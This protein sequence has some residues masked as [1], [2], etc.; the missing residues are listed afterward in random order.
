MKSI[1]FIK[2]VYAINNNYNIKI[3]NII[4]KLVIIKYVWS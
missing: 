2:N 3:E 1:Y 4:I